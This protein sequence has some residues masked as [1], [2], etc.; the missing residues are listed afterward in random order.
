[1]RGLPARDGS[2]AAQAASARRI[3]S[4]VET[5][6]HRSQDPSWTWVVF[7]VELR[8]QFVHASGLHGGRAF[9]QHLQVLLVT[10]DIVEQRRISFYQGR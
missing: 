9:G 2:N 1:M 8:K 6:E 3:L 5:Q 4:F 7:E 10:R